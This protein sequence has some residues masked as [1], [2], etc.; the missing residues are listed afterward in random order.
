MHANRVR[1]Y[2][3]FPK[4]KYNDREQ[5]VYPGRQAG[6]AEQAAE[7]SGVNQYVQYRQGHC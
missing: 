6:A 7:A 1:F 2:L 4:R 5:N 3:K